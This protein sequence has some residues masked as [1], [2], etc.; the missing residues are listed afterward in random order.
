[1]EDNMDKEVYLN[2]IAEKIEDILKEECYVDVRQVFRSTYVK[3]NI[4]GPR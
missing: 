3:L 4:N 1:M 2:R